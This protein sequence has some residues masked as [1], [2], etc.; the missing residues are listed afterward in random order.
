MK[1][2]NVNTYLLLLCVLLCTSCGT[3]NKIRAKALLE[4][5][6]AIQQDIKEGAYPAI[7]A[8]EQKL[9]EILG[10]DMLANS[11]CPEITSVINAMKGDLSSY[12]KRYDDV[13]S[14]MDFIVETLLKLNVISLNSIPT[15]LQNTT[16]RKT[17]DR[18]LLDRNAMRQL[19]FAKNFK[20][21]EAAIKQ[22]LEKANIKVSEM[23]N[24]MGL[25]FRQIN[26]FSYNLSFEIFKSEYNRFSFPLG[27]FGV[28]HLTNNNKKVF[29]NSMKNLVNS[30]DAVKQTI[31]GDVKIM[32]MAW[33][34][35]DPSPVSDQKLKILFEP[36]ELPGIMALSVEERIKAGNLRLSQKRSQTVSK[37]IIN[38]LIEKSLMNRGSLD[39]CTYGFGTEK[40]DPSGVYTSDKDANRR[41]VKCFYHIIAPN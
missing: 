34:Y 21:A 8:G 17:F 13:N 2:N 26:V 32:I 22:L 27:E 29:E 23:K 39:M 28:E 35:A 14:S 12:K 6:N 7:S 19:E 10:N 9:D 24:E 33:G 4:T 20:N 11:G 31:G 3:S 41:I 30:Y 15:V 25:T 1:M 16:N 36:D 18:N 5:C 40:P 37:Y 38:Y